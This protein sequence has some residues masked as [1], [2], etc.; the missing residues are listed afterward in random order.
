MLDS[1]IEAA[2]VGPEI[3]DFLGRCCNG[4][5]QCLD[6]LKNLT[7]LLCVD[8]EFVARSSYAVDPGRKNCAVVKLGE[9]KVG[10][11]GKRVWV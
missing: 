1:S 5:I 8:F 9:V 6:G 10:E 2:N 11:W 7:V 4:A 3:R